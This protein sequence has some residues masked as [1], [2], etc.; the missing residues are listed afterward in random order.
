MDGLRSGLGLLINLFCGCDNGVGGEDATAGQ[1]R[2]RP[3]PPSRTTRAHQ[4]EPMRLLYRFSAR[5]ALPRGNGIDSP[6]VTKTGRARLSE[7]AIG[8]SSRRIHGNPIC[9]GHRPLVHIERPHK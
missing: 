9:I 8:R 2:T 1:A 4:S 3:R 6:E 7:D 5:R